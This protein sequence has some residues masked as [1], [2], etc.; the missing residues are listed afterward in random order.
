MPEGFEAGQEVAEPDAARE[1]KHRGREASGLESQRFPDGDDEI[2]SFGPGELGELLC[3]IFRGPV[4]HDLKDDL[5]PVLVGE[6]E[7]RDEKGF[8][9][10]KDRGLPREARG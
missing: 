7:I 10:L 4:A 1:R 6:D 5:C 3:Q 9:R 8:S 2:R